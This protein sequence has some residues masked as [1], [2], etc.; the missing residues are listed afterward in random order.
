MM[1]ANANILHMKKLYI[2][3]THILK[4]KIIAK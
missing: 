1:I 2:E 3:K 4:S